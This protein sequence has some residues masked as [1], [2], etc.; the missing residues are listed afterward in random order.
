MKDPRYRRVDTMTIG[1][2]LLFLFVFLA[3]M[4]SRI[5]NNRE[6]VIEAQTSKLETMNHLA[7]SSMSDYFG[8]ISLSL[9]V[10]DYW[11]AKNATAD[12]RFDPYFYK[13]ISILETDMAGN[14]DFRLVSKGGGLYCIPSDSK[15]PLA[16]VSDRQYFQVQQ[17]E[18]TKGFYIANPVLSPVTG[19]WGIPISYPLTAENSGMSVIFAT[20]EMPTLENL[21][22]TFQMNQSGTTLLV[23]EDG[24]IMATAPFMKALI[25]TRLDHSSFWTSLV[26][27]N[28]IRTADVTE[29]TEIDGMNR[30][31]AI[32]EVTGFPLYILSTCSVDGVMTAWQTTLPMNILSALALVSGLLLVAFV[33]YRVVKH[34]DQAQEDIRVLSNTDTLTGLPNRR[35]FSELLHNE[36]A[37]V[38]R[39]GGIFSVA[40]VDVDHFKAVN[41]TFGHE[42]GDN[43]LKSLAHLMKASVRKSDMVARWGGEEFVILLLN[44]DI[45]QANLRT[46]QIRSIIESTPFD[47][48]E[49]VTASFGITQY[50]AEDSLEGLMERADR[51]MYFSKTQGGNRT[52]WEQS[53]VE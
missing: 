19:K 39:Y 43:L 7:A 29:A 52:T 37:R 26:Q 42:T 4:T 6:R 25:G 46:E 44:A 21:F 41:D 23:R 22:S 20:L 17:H 10:A 48:P 38:Q 18:E 1:L 30:Y 27:Q 45:H 8:K 15:K 51:M 11:L 36:I 28:T 2:I 3:L 47:K 32:T 34:L 50:Q 24:T 9:K 49:R 40:M 16:N 13:F 14:A 5:T 35:F 31:V 33:M 53:Q 12:P